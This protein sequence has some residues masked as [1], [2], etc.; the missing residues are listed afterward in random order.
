MISSAGLT[1]DA[2][3][4]AAVETLS[5]G[6]DRVVIS[7]SADRG[8]AGVQVAEQCQGVGRIAAH[9]RAS[10]GPQ[11][12]R[13]IGVMEFQHPAKVNAIICR[14]DKRVAR[15]LWSDL[16]SRLSSRIDFRLEP[17]FNA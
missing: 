10:P 6:G 3:T 8:N 5:R 17:A 4:E 16:G 14:I 11:S 15:C 7:P 12:V 13:W 9:K 1:A 2:Y